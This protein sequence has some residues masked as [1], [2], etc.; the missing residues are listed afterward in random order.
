MNKYEMVVIVDAALPGQEKE[1][2]AKE[3]CDTISKNEGKVI[4]SQVWIDR[5]KFPFSMKKKNEGT[6]YAIN[7]ESQPSAVV[8]IRQT[9]KIN[10]KI[11]R[12]MILSAGT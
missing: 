7:F 5:H 9:L 4:N 3:V 6:Y 11:L 12:F 10:E 2:V 8:K 1:N